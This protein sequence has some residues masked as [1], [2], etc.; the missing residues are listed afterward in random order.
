[1]SS[2][3]APDGPDS[4]SCAIFCDLVKNSRVHVRS[5]RWV[6]RLLG[7]RLIIGRV[8]LRTVG[9][10][11]SSSSRIPQCLFKNVKCTSAWWAFGSC[12]SC[13]ILSRVPGNMYA[14]RW[15]LTIGHVET[16]QRSPPR[17]PKD[18]LRCLEKLSSI[19][20]IWYPWLIYIAWR[21]FWLSDWFCFRLKLRRTLNLNSSLKLKQVYTTA[22]SIV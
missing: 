12:A 18:G 9:T 6:I 11:Q 7:W 17:I 14:A 10:F 19:L 1:M 3:Q 5:A 2:A 15:Q 13:V 20:S 21:I 22:L 4:V 8:E 16:L